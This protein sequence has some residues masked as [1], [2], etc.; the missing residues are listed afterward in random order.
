MDQPFDLSSL[1]KNL[2]GDEQIV[3]E[4]LEEFVDHYP[5]RLE[6]IKEAIDSGNAIL[7]TRTAHSYK[8]AISNFGAT[9]AQRIAS[10]LET[11]GTLKQV[12]QALP[13]WHE[14][15]DE[16]KRFQEHYDRIVATTKDQ[17]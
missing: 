16:M 14:L 9:R 8:G 1:M 11:Y 17:G 4:L 7:L 3:F 5:Q 6:E 12:D 15:V 10:E 2:S 13:A